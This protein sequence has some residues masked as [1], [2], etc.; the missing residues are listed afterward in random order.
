MGNKYLLIVED[1]KTEQKIFSS[2][3]KKYGFNVTVESKKLEIDKFTFA[4]CKSLTII[5]IPNNVTEINE[6]LLYKDIEIEFMTF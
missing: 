6:L 5:S 3:L 1:A 2:V 4:G